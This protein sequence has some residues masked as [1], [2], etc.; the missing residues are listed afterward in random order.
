MQPHSRV[1]DELDMYNDDVSDGDHD[2]E[3]SEDVTDTVPIELSDSDQNVN[4]SRYPLVNKWPPQR[5]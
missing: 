4:S 1:Q 2:A 3:P 5:D